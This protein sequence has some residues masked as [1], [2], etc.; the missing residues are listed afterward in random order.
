MSSRI[1]LEGPKTAVQTSYTERKVLLDLQRKK[2]AGR[3]LR[4][5]AKDYD[6]ITYGDIQRALKGD[7]PK[8]PHK[9]LVLGLP[10]LIPA[11]ACAKC[12]NVHVTKRCPN[13]QKPPNNWRDGEAWWQ[14]LM[15]WFN[16][17]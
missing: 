7:F 10:A 3:S 4:A 1:P 9:R 6:G 16:G 15:D 8:S 11:P 5:I 17:G 12:G 2:A 14:R 13:G